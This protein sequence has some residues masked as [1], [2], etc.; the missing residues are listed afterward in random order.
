MNLKPCP[1]CGAD[2][3]S[4]EPTDDYLGFTAYCGDC[5]AEGPVELTPQ[6]AKVSWDNREELNDE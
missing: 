1:F 4:L 5:E 2:N 6:A 3:I